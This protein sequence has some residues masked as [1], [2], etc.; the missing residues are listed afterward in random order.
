MSTNSMYIGDFG[1]THL[2]LVLGNGVN[3]TCSLL[4]S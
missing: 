4:L 2:W 3:M 1:G